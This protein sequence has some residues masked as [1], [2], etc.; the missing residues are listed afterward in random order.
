MKKRHLLLYVLMTCMVLPMLGGDLK[1]RYPRSLLEKHLTKPGTFAPVPR[2][3]D[4]YWQKNVPK[5]MRDSYIRV[6][7]AY[8]GKPWQA[9]RLDLF[10][11]F[12]TN[13]NR[14]NYENV[15]FEK[16]RQLG[17][18]AIAEIMEGKGRFMN[19][20]VKGLQ[21]M[22][23][24]TWWGIPAHYN[25]DHPVKND[26]TVDLFNAETANLMVWISYMLRDKI[27]KKA[28]K[29]CGQ[30]QDEV[31]RRVLQPA[32]KNDYWW[33][34]AGNNWNPW[35]CSNWLSCVL[36]CETD[37]KLQVDAVE[38]IIGC[39]DIFMDSYSE[40]GGCDEGPGYWNHAAASLYDALYL[41]RLST[42]GVID[43]SNN[44]KLKNMGSFIYKTYIGGGKSINFADN[45]GNNTANQVDVVF[46]F[47]VYLNDPTMCSFARSLWQ[48]DNRAGDEYRKRG[49]FTSLGREMVFLSMIDRFEKAK[50]QEPNNPDGWLPDLQI[51]TA[52]DQHIFVAMKGGHNDES[53]NHNDVGSFIIYHDNQPLL[54]DPSVG[55]YTAATFGNNRYAIWTMQ[56]GYHNLP[57]INGV[58]QHEGK[59]YRARQV[60]YQP[61]TLSM[62]IAGAYPSSAAVKRWV[63]QTRLVRNNYVEIQEDYE[64]KKYVRPTKIMLLT[65]TRPKISSGKVVLGNYEIQ[66]NKKELNATFENIS[67]KLD[68]TLQ[69]LWGKEMYRIV[70]TI[71]GKR[72]KGTITYKVA[73]R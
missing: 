62:D 44:Q 23:E 47:G 55:A 36:F 54:I 30:I 43:L 57:Q 33:K 16:R 69:N 42:G 39:L 11:E 3:G 1:N 5:A 35:I 56:S 9:M 17:C 26:Q 2:A 60:N 70:L 20:L 67:D 22:I 34:R 12:K 58:D 49:N 45:H 32:L 68:K 8:L 59:D 66:Y 29:L 28:P 61:G 15:C 18:L 27:N 7:E 53:H 10:K 4:A 65:T 51:M 6:G 25:T 24:E 19:D 14:T 48:G 31:K 13:G 38:Q 37:R 64:L 46:P 50:A 21:S 63:R 41:L 73:R 52:R 40:D 71:K 72:T